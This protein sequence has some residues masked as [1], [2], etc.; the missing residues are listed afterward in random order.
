MYEKS[1]NFLLENAGPIIKYRLQKEIL[2]NLTEANEKKLL[3][4]IYQTPHFKLLESYIKPNG[5]IGIGMHSWDKFKE[6]PLQDG[7]AASRL[8]SYYNIPKTNPIISNFVKAMRN[9]KILKTEFS[10][11]NPEK[12]RYE[13]RFLGLHSGFSLMVLVY[14]MQ[15]LLGYGDDYDDLKEFQNVSFQ[16]FKKILSISSLDD[17]TKFN[18]NSKKKYNYPYIE[19][20]T[21]FP[22]SYN[23]E[24]LA[25]TN[26]WKTKEN[27]KLLI[28][29]IN[30]LNE[31]MQE[32]NNLH[33]KIRNRYYSPLWAL[34]RPIKAFSLDLMQYN[35]CMYRRP[36]TEIAMLGV[37]ENVKIIKDSIINIKEALS[38]DGIIHI[39]FDNAYN[40]KRYLTMLKYSTNYSEI[41]LEE[42]YRKEIALECDLTFWAIQF[43]KYTEK[44]Q[45][46]T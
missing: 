17:L 40:K 22:C 29:A 14:T 23:L 16:T 7:E 41:G 34:C 8:L 45:T 13:E 3:K 31:I 20:K 30:H 38:K 21:Y 44:S 25:Y 32:G 19:E 39:K 36:L 11:Y 9:E 1:I 6:S 26:N 33:I 10:Y 4:E 15:A 12:T 28:N 5:Y 27:L 42:D 46:S 24:M 43:L 37:G 18:P 2:N 35:Y